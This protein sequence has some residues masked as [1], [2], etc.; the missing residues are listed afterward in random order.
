MVFTIRPSVEASTAS[1]RKACG[2]AATTTS[3][4]GSSD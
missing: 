4:K 3:G 1:F 2:A